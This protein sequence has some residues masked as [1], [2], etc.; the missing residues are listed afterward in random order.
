[1]QHEGLFSSHYPLKKQ[2]PAEVNGAQV[3]GGQGDVNSRTSRDG[4]LWLNQ[5]C[6]FSVPQKI[7]V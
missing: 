7:H 4:Q 2:D 5:L 1:M 3:W 6:S